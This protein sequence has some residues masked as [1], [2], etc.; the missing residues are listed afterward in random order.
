VI[1]EKHWRDAISIIRSTTDIDVKICRSEYKSSSK[2]WIIPMQSMSIGTKGYEHH[3]ILCAVAHEYGHLLSVRR[4]SPA[5]MGI[6]FVYNAMP[7]CLTNRQ[8]E[9]IAAEETTAWRLGFKFL[10]DNNLPVDSDMRYARKI[11]LG[12]L[13][14]QLWSL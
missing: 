13:K 7:H 10:K 11:L 12:G 1:T 8:K 3:L 2:P 6:Y 14:E 4:G 5:N 9:M